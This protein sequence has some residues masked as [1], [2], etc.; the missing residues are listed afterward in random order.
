MHTGIVF[1][2]AH[3]REFYKQ[4]GTIICDIKSGLSYLV[5]SLIMA[6]YREYIVICQTL[7]DGEPNL[8]ATVGV[9]LHSLDWKIRSLSDQ[10][11]LPALTARSGA[12]IYPYMFGPAHSGISEHESAR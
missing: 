10:E 4:P 2:F 1:N 5:A 8:N 11:P 9:K 6:S 7:L 3:A 12:A